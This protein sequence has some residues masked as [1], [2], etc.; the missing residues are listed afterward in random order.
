[1][2]SQPTATDADIDAAVATLR[3]GGLIGLPTETVYGLG[4]DAT[5]EAAVQRI[6]ATKGRPAGHPL[7]V[8]VA[9]AQQVDEWSTGSDARAAALAEAF[10]PGPLT[11]IVESSGLAAPSVTGGRTT[12]GLRVPDHPVALEVLRRFGG[13]V[14]APSANRFGH[15]SPTTADH[16]RADLGDA[17]DVIL[18]GGPSKVGVES[19]IIEL[20]GG[21]PV[22][23]RPGGVSVEAIEAVLGE[24]V[25]DGRTGESRAAG[26]MASHYAPDAPVVVVESIDGPLDDRVAVIAPLGEPVLD[27]ERS[28]VQWLP[29]DAAGFAEG[30]YA[31]LRRADSADTTQI[32][33]VAPHEAG[34]LLPAVM[35]RL[36]KASAPR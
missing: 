17:V 20:V 22:L 34:D 12:V 18:D 30:L 33:V 5:N 23:L 6:F 15:V 2:T 1:M 3:A 26:M 14:A 4:A 16:V 31:A 36:A 8:H 28:K 11:I 13:G 10:W 29:A 32:M 19:T 27:P 24:S 9:S 35:D 21:A 7:I 25:V